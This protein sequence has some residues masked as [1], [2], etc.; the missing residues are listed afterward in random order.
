MDISKGRLEFY[1]L[2]QQLSQKNEPRKSCQMNECEKN[3]SRKVKRKL[4]QRIFFI[5]SLMGVKYF[6]LNST[7]LLRGAW[8]R[9]MNSPGL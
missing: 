4:Y 1:P 3:P 7:P 2:K 6:P 5:G 9:F 8:A